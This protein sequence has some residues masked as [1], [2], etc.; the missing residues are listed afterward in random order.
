MYHATLVDALWNDV[1]A[2]AGSLEHQFQ[3]LLLGPLQS[4]NPDSIPIGVIVI[5]ALDECESDE[6]IENL[7][8]II[9]KY[10]SNLHVKFFTS[11][12]PDFSAKIHIYSVLYSHP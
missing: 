5:D 11:A 9:L 10:A 3:K 12:K 6:A 1:Y 8:S 2:Q 4:I 7:L